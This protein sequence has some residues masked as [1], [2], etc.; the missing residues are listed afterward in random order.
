MP[1]S[2][3]QLIER[4][5]ASDNEAFRLLFE[6]YQPILFRNVLHKVRDAD[7]AH[8]IVQETF[9]RVWR[10]RTS[11]QSNLSFLAYLFRISGNLV[12]DN[13]KH[14]EVRARLKGSIPPTSPS[15]QDDPE[16][17]LELNMLEEKLSEVVRTK[18]PTKCRAIF[19]LSRLEGMSNAEISLKLNVSIKTVENH[20]TRALKLLRRN[21]RG[22]IKTR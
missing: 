20:M 3:E 12:R 21:L 19:L 4:V 13:A 16:S 22:Y 9:V 2:D 7:A 15:A 6:K 8:D 1:E 18:L 5:R 14:R 11:L 17:S 10:N